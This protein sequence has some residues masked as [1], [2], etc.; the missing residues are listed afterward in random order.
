MDVKDLKRKAAAEADN[1]VF[2]FNPLKKDFTWNYNKI[3]FTIPSQESKSF[4]TPIAEHLGKHLV[5]A[6][7]NTKNSDYS[8][9]KA[10]KL[11]FPDD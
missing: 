4:K 7:L 5:D 6:Y 10:E 9:E 3:P 1:D 8:R 2:I 11:I